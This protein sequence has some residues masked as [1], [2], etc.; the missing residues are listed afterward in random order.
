MARTVADD[1]VPTPYRRTRPLEQSVVTRRAVLGGATAMLASPAFARPLW[2]SV[3]PPRI[4]V[5]ISRGARARVH[6]F[7]FD[8]AA[9]QDSLHIIELLDRLIVV[10]VDGLAFARPDLGQ[11]WRIFAKP[12]ARRYA[13]SPGGGR[14]D[15][16]RSNFGSLPTPDR[17]RA[18]IGI[19][20]G[21]PIEVRRVARAGGERVMVG[22]PR[23]RILITGDIVV[24]GSPDS[25]YRDQTT[26]HRAAL[27]LCQSLP[28]TRI[29]P[30][31][32][33]PGGRELYESMLYHIDGSRAG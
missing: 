20:S 16:E 32:G 7:S 3:P 4:R 18:G 25:R 8:G 29:L 17:A 1:M 33:R 23:D 27:T 24:N 28:Y 2:P 10:S 30:S 26:E 9:G 15:D 22:L 13:T 11:W 5:D 6:T 14:P 19:I 12:V 21:E 31:R